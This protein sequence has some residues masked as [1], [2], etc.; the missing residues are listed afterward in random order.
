MRMRKTRLLGCTNLKLE[1]SAALLADL[2]RCVAYVARRVSLMSRFLRAVPDLN[3]RTTAQG[4]GRH[5]EGTMG[6]P[7]AVDVQVASSQA[8]LAKTQLLDDT[9]ACGVRGPDVDLD[10]MQPQDEKRV[11]AGGRQR[12]GHDPLAGGRLGNPVAGRG[13]A[14]GA[15]GD[16]EQVHLADQPSFGLDA[17]RLEAPLRGLAIEMLHEL[18]KCHDG[19]QR[20]G[21]C[22]FPGPEPLD[23]LGPQR[24]P[25]APVPDAQWSQGHRCAADPSGADGHWPESFPQWSPP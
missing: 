2:P 9:Q 8:L 20:F 6:T 17:K 10:P 3:P 22:G 14:Q 18:A 4:L 19:C 7:L 1:A 12:E 21:R 24:L 25:L 23:V 15:P 13:R 16:P 5:G 11:V